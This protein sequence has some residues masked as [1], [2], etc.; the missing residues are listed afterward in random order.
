MTLF[1]IDERRMLV[2]WVSGFVE[3][4]AFDCENVIPM[5]GI[6]FVGSGVIDCGRGV[7]GVEVVGDSDFDRDLKENFCFGT[8]LSFSAD[9]SSDN[10][11][12][13]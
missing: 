12:S 2:A 5:S 3:R 13:C 9:N 8:F 10:C 4:Y 7:D 11:F 6:V 1:D